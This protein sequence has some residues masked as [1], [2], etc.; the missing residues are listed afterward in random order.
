VKLPKGPG[1]TEPGIL[2]MASPL[3]DGTFEIAEMVLL[4]T[5]TSSLRLGPPRLTLA[6]SRFADAKPVATQVQV[7]AGDQP[8]LVPG[9]RIKRSTVLLLNAPAKHIELRYNL[10]G[11]T[12]RSMP[13]RA[14]RAVAAISP[15]VAAAPETLPV[16]MMVSGP[17]VL[18]IGCP[19]LRSLSDRACSVGRSP[20]L[21]VKK[22]LQ[23]RKA[24]I[25]VQFDLPRP[26]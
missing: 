18:N 26:Q 2:L 11:I 6:G 15:L 24:V 16:A 7:S 13:S 20:Q 14:G 19:T 17:T 22:E 12:I 23:W 4:P 5:P 9:G 21:R 25:V 8:V 1:T 3:R 10:S